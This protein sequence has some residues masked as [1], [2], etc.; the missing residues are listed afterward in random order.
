MVT[1]NA[2]EKG[3]EPSLFLFRRKSRFREFAGLPICMFSLSERV[4]S[5]TGGC[6]QG[7]V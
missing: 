3:T 1:I 5:G 4:C 6:I 2:C 7:H